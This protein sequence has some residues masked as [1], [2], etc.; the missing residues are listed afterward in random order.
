MIKEW[1]REIELVLRKI[2]KMG[3][4]FQ[5]NKENRHKVTKLEKMK[6]LQ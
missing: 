3:E 1:I 2:N 5:I 6:T 4:H